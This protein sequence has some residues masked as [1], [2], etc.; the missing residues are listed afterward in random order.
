M[1]IQTADKILL[2][3]TGRAPGSRASDDWFTPRRYLESA[4][5]VFAGG[6]IDLDPFS[7][8]AANEIVQARRFY[9]EAD[10][11]FSLPW[12]SRSLWLNPPYSRG[13]CAK[14]VMYLLDAWG[15]GV[16]GEALALLN[17]CTETGWFQSA[18]TAA[19][20]VCLT[21]HRVAFWNADGKA[22]SG[23]TRGQAFLYFG[24]A[25]ERF[26]AEFRRHGTVVVADPGDDEAVGG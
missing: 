12:D 14:A 6:V 21:H 11:G 22:V 7:C 8:A 5:R 13:Q 3:Y 20:A 10:D 23:N 25:R 15:C 19:T 16:V 2:A 4:R 24:P 1:L 17:N 26:C 18:L 9:S